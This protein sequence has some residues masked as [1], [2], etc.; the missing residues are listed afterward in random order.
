MSVQQPV[1]TTLREKLLVLLPIKHE[2]PFTFYTRQS[3][4]KF[5]TSLSYHV[6]AVGFQFNLNSTINTSP[7]TDVCIVLRE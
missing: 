4:T 1:I 2:E 6:V 7:V 3:Q 5:L